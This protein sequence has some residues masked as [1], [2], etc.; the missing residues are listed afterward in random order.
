VPTIYVSSEL[1]D[2]Y[3]GFETSMLSKNKLTLWNEKPL[4]INEL[5]I[6]VGSSVILTIDEQEVVVKIG[7]IVRDM[8]PIHLESTSSP[9]TIIASDAF[10]EKHTMHDTYQFVKVFVDDSADI[11]QVEVS[12][13][14]IENHYFVNLDER[15][16]RYLNEL[17]LG[18]LFASSL[19]LAIIF[20][21]AISQQSA[22]EAMAVQ[23]S[24]RNKLLYSIGMERSRIVKAEI[25]RRIIFVGISMTVGFMLLMIYAS[26]MYRELYGELFIKASLP[27]KI[28]FIANYLME[29]IQ[30]W[31]LPAIFI[32][33]L[34]LIFP[35]K[36]KN[37]TLM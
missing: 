30:F 31:I 6:S 32:L 34:V 25:G 20:I 35:K 23:N 17:L 3:L 28:I 12:L 4:T 36:E 11:G 19:C 26:L 27:N 2:S 33:I 22:R 29:I 14:R 15:V 1:Y 10:L 21:V 24:Y 37:V 5:T 8:N 13:S 9:F 16:G 18:V 7:A